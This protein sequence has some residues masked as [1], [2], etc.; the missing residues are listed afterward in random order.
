MTRQ[1][2]D[3]GSQAEPGQLLLKLELRLFASTANTLRL[4]LLLGPDFTP[5][6]RHANKCLVATG[7][8]LKELGDDVVRSVVELFSPSES[9]TAWHGACLALAELARLGLLLPIHGL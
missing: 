3:F 7:T 2:Q 4:Q 1:D 9:D 6:Q 8:C 5:P